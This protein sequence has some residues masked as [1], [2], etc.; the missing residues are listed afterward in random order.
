MAKG[1][2]S[3][4]H[5]LERQRQPLVGIAWEYANQRFAGPDRPQADPTLLGRARVWPQP[6]PP[7]RQILRTRRFF[8]ASRHGPGAWSGIIMNR[9]ST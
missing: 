5:R 2:R 3:L 1:D 9:V 6:Q 8:F 4:S 7:W